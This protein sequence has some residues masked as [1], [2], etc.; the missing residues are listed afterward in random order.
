MSISLCIYYSYVYNLSLLE[1]R[2]MILIQPLLYLMAMQM[3]L[4]IANEHSIFDY[5]ALK[6]I[7]LTKG[8]IKRLFYTLCFISALL[9][10]FLPTTTVVLIFGSFI[11]KACKIIN[12][13]ARPFLVGIYTCILPGCLLTPFSSANILI[14]SSEYELNILWF[15]QNIHPFIIP[16]IIITLIIIDRKYLQ[17]VLK[18]TQIDD[19]KINL[20][21]ELLRP[22]SVIMDKKAFKKN[23][24]LIILT[25]ICLLL[26]PAPFVVALLACLIV[27]KSNKKNVSKFMKKVDW[28]FI[29]YLASI[30]MT[31]GCMKVSGAFDIF[32]NG[33]TFIAENIA[34]GNIILILVFIIVITGLVA[35]FFSS[36]MITLIMLAIFKVW[37]AAHPGYLDYINLFVFALMTSI[38]LGMNLTPHGS[39]A[40]L[41]TKDIAEKNGI[42]DLTYKSI[43][44][45]GYKITFL[46]L[47]IVIVYLV[48][49]FYIFY[50]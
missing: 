38:V 15:I 19:R 8:N 1:I 39:S 31:V 5:V 24:I 50:Q 46:H 44:S 42:T 35:G 3:I 48:L 29:L 25:F 27:L 28:K 34:G 43:F 7:H 20:L 41:L 30:Y 13:N 4:E 22:E 49:R 47:L 36:S 11:I 33:I 45:F 6:L 18:D 2:G 37:F 23:S 16:L 32:A 40:T 14:I 21:L 10:G 12:I 9:A 17:P 26:F